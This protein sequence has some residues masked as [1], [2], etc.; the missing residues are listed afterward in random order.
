MNA[1]LANDMLQ[2]TPPSPANVGLPK[3]PVQLDLQKNIA[4][5]PRPMPQ[6]HPLQTAGSGGWDLSKGLSEGLSEAGNFV[7]SRMGSMGEHMSLAPLGHRPDFRQHQMG[8]VQVD[9]SAATENTPPL[10]M[11]GATGQL[12]ESFQSPANSV[13]GLIQKGLK[14]PGGAGNFA[15]L[16]GGLAPGLTKGLLSTPL[17]LPALVGMHGL[18]RGGDS[19]AAAKTFFNPLLSKIGVS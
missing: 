11:M 10:Q 8:P 14:M 6:P 13:L 5:A 3:P 1:K 4:P 7:K 16:M 12:P 9:M 2:P 17:G 19:F 15:G 18:L